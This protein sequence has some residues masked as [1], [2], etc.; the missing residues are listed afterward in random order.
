MRLRKRTS[1]RVMRPWRR[2]TLS[3]SSRFSRL[4][5]HQ[6]SLRPINHVHA[7]RARAVSTVCVI[8][9]PGAFCVVEHAERPVDT[10]CKNTRPARPASPRGRLIIL[11]YTVSTCVRCIVQ[12]CTPAICSG[13]M[14][15]LALVLFCLRLYLFLVLCI[16][17]SPSPTDTLAFPFVPLLYLSLFLFAPS[18]PL[19]LVLLSLSYSFIIT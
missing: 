3:Q 8:K 18:G 1:S 17:A 6:R 14:M 9:A 5:N 10:D 12:A 16:T 11:L 2:Q 13:D 4:K 15:L 19:S 7:I